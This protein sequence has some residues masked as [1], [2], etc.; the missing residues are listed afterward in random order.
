M[1][2]AISDRDLLSLPFPSIGDH[3]MDAIVEGVRSAL[4][5]PAIFGPAET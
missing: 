3:A 4:T 1:Y 2:P 5:C